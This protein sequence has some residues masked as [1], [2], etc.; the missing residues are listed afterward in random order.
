[1]GEGGRRSASGDGKLHHH[2]AWADAKFKA[3]PA[4][5]FK[6]ASRMARNEN[7]KEL[8]DLVTKTF[9]DRAS[10][11]RHTHKSVFLTMQEA[12]IAKRKNSV[13]AFAYKE[14]A[15]AEE[16]KHNATA[17]EA[18]HNAKEPQQELKDPDPLPQPDSEP[19]APDLHM[20]VHACSMHVEQISHAQC[21]QD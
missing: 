13:R 18:K 4:G 3:R 10:P 17:E 2:K 8:K 14:K 21:H 9:Q 6:F 1:M 16:A 7:F 19:G 12:G 20:H 11:G 15:T 5:P